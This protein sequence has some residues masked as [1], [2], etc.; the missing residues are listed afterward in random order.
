VAPKGQGELKFVPPGGAAF[1]ARFTIAVRADL[2]GAPGGCL[3]LFTATA[4]Q[5]YILGE[6][7]ADGHVSLVTTSHA[8]APVFGP[9]QPGTVHTL[10]LSVDSSSVRLAVDGK[11]VGRLALPSAARYQ[12]VGLSVANLGTTSGAALL[13]DFVYMPT[14]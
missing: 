5:L 2:T 3:G 9:D 13:S 1:P 10:A 8:I 4:S 6:L 14:P 11:A 12:E 7:C